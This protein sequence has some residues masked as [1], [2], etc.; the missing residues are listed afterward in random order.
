MSRVVVAGSRDLEDAEL[1][2]KAIRDS[3]FTIKTLLSGNCPTGVDRIGEEWARANGVTVEPHPALWDKEGY[4]RAGPLRNMR[5]AKACDAAI[6]VLWESGS[7]GSES[8]IREARAL[9][10]PTFVVRVPGSAPARAKRGD[11]L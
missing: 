5:M 7:S 11:Q 9:G 2:H 10:R 3:G 1:V 6:V 4:P 8:M